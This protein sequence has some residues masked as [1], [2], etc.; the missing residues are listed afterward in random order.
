LITSTKI[1]LY[2]T[3]K[4]LVNNQYF[5]Y[6]T[7]YKDLL[8]LTDDLSYQTPLKSHNQIQ[9]TVYD[10]YCYY[11][12]TNKEYNQILIK[13]SLDNFQPEMNLNLTKKYPDIEYFLGFTITNKSLITF[14]VFDSN[15]RYQLLFC[16]EIHNYNLIKK[17]PI[18]DSIDTRKIVSTLLP[19]IRMNSIGNNKSKY[20]QQLWFILDMKLNCIHCLIHENYLTKI[21]SKTSN[22]IQSI[23]IFDEKL[24]LAY[25]ELSV[26]IIDLDNYFSSFKL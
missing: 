19:N 14:L 24:F 4:E 2:D 1:V 18:N 9:S 6:D 11:L 20:G 5:L 13:C 25:N 26:E 23:S 8:L 7:L 10:D 12:Y 3:I 16:D 21:S 17:L 15:N 22:L